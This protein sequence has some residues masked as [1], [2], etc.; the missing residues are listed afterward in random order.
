MSIEKSLDK[1][2]LGYY[3]EALAILENC[4][5][6]PLAEKL[7]QL[8]LSM[9]ALTTYASALSKGDLAVE[10]PDLASPVAKELREL[11]L[12]LKRLSRHLLMAS[13]GYSAPS[14]N[15]MGDLS[16][17]LCFLMAQSSQ[18]QQQATFGRDY[19]T[20][21]GLLN[22]KALIRGIFDVLQNQPNK[23]G[24][25]LCYGLDNL[26]YINL[27]HGYA[28]GDLY[29]SKVVEALLAF[30]GETSIVARVGGNEFAVYAHGFDD[31]EAASA[32]AQNNLLYLFKTQVMLPHEA[33]K[34]RASC[35]T[36]IYP[37]DA[38]ACDTLMNY[39]SQARFEVQKTNRGTIMRFS[40][41]HYHAK[42]SLLNRQERLDEL[43]E[44]KLF[45]FDFQPIVDLKKNSILGY[46]ALMRPRTANFSGPLDILA[47]AEAQS[48]L[49]QLEK[50]TFDQIFRWI[51]QN[52]ELLDGKKI[53][54]NTI[55]TD[56][57][58]IAKLQEIHPQYE[59]ISKCMV[60][61]ILETV[62]AETTLLKKVNALRDKLSVLIAIDD[63]GCGHSNTLRLI[64]VAPD[65]LKFDRFFITSIHKA[66]ASKNELLANILSYC[67]TQ[68]ILTL[69]EGVETS[70]E[71]ECVIEMGFDYIQGFYI[72]RP[73]KNLMPIDPAIQAELARLTSRKNIKK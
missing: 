30:S 8:A 65:I 57:L 52:I 7:Q 31:E 33:V 2:L 71:L 53:F 10:S 16:E 37:H 29:I 69:A 36:A 27:A 46:E 70:E 6:S 40:S 18:K 38:V 64:N 48:K 4:E 55:S 20:D 50:A 3:A 13:T 34:V 67:R 21:T 23:V 5:P 60:F 66:A 51:D 11:H 44:E 9:A 73:E 22:R 1:L 54:F 28:S 25:L 63:F 61:E 41:E 47:L 35:G 12:N 15:Y 58:D 17:G 62:S 56:Y 43:I 59:A 32:F 39:A 49:P 68:K 42:A 14:L 72:G 45:R 19:D 26:K 24:I